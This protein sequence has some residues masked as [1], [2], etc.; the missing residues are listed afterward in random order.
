MSHILV[1]YFS[2]TGKTGRIAKA[3]ARACGADLFEICPQAPYTAADLNWTDSKSL[4]SLEMADTTYRPAIKGPL[5]DLSGYDTLLLGFPIWWGVE[6]RAV[7][8]FLDAVNLSGKRVFGFC[9]S[10][11]SG[12]SEAQKRLTGLYPA[13][14]LQSVK[15]LYG[16]SGV[17]N[18]IRSLNL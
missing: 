16:T 15:L 8:T 17:E 13:L 9:T 18:W 3:A 14:E 12:S 1:A 5:P 4:S 10:G 2:A 7:D 11:G 6:P